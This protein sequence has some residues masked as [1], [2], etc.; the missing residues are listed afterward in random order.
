MIFMNKQKS[1][2]PPPNENFR[3]PRYASV[4]RV[5]IN[6]FEGEAVL[7]NISTGGFR[8]ESKTYVAIEVGEHYVM[9][10]KPEA[11]SNLRPFE[12]EVEV[13]WIQSSETSFTAGFLVIK[14]PA[15]RSFEKHVEYI[16]ARN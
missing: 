6:G 13:R 2:N 14:P 4:A 9:Q 3:P 7:R 1:D 11:A 12:L 5:G 15:D 10:I 16:K 8:M